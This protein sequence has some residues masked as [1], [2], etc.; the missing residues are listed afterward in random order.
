MNL[1]AQSWPK[2]ALSPTHGPVH[3]ALCAV[4]RKSAGAGR[5][6]CTDRN[7][8]KKE[9]SKQA[10]QIGANQRALPR[11]DRVHSKRLDEQGRLPVPKRGPKRRPTAVYA[12]GSEPTEA[13]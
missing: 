7:S 8:S 12:G 3:F 1:R 13:L 11:A 6:R 10:T 4:V 9:R 2:P 5:G